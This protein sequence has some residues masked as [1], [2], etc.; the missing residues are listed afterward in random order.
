MINLI[1]SLKRKYT[2]TIGE[3][4]PDLYEN[5]AH[6]IRCKKIMKYF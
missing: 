2:L 4:N 5:F 1:I 3:Q 6:Y